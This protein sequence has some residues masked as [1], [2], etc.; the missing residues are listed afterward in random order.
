LTEN[1]VTQIARCSAISSLVLAVVIGLLAAGVP[2]Q[3]GLYRWIA[4]LTPAT[5][6]LRGLSPAFMLPDEYRYSFEDVARTDLTGQTAVVTGANGGVGYWVSL[7]LARQGASVV[8]ACRTLHKCDTAAARI[9]SNFSDADIT[10]LTIDTS[11]QRV[12]RS[13]AVECDRVL[14]ARPLDMLFLNA[15]IQTAGYDDDGGLPVSEDGIEMVFATNHVGHQLLYTLLE[16]ALQAAPMARVVLTTSA[17]QFDVPEYGVPTDLETLNKP[18][19]ELKPYPYGQSKLAQVLFAQELTRRLPAVSNIYVNLAHP[20]AVDTG[21]YD[22]MNLG[23]GPVR[24]LVQQL[25]DGFF[26]DAED[27][28]VGLLYLGLATDALKSGNVRGQYFHPQAT[29]VDPHDKFA[30]DS[31]F[32]QAVWEFTDSLIVK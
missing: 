5:R 14:G 20:G 21:L 31:A 7:H 15:G 1:V 19:K 24:W 11:K 30:T 10:T 28:A 9:R 22:K 4:H 29:R 13:F 23:S 6:G 3:L 2:T 27:A 8:M 25:Q 12:V 26:W 32:G 18:G 17:A 16:P